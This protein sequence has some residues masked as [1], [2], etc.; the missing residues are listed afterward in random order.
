MEPVPWHTLPEGTWS[1][2][3]ASRSCARLPASR[4]WDH[5]EA[6]GHAPLTL[7]DS[8]WRKPSGR[9]RII[10]SFLRQEARRHLGSQCPFSPPGCLSYDN[11]KHLRWALQRLG[12][13]VE[14]PQC[15]CGRTDEALGLCLPG[16]WGPPCVLESFSPDF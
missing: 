5:R 6:T 9:A 16:W 8:G 10:W 1:W 13:H 11:P 14:K 12:V 2:S 7:V 4:L 15:F 3:P